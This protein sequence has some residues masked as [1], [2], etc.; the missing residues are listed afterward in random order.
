[1]FQLTGDGEL[2]DLE[3]GS[4]YS[5]LHVQIVAYIVTLV[6]GIILSVIPVQQMSTRP[7]FVN[8]E[9]TA[10]GTFVTGAGTA[11]TSGPL[12]LTIG[13]SFNGVGGYSVHTLKATWLMSTSSTVKP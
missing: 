5:E 10:Y 3:T 12:P 4:A 13:R 9:E 2:P 11:T 6:L 8:G 1:M 7:L